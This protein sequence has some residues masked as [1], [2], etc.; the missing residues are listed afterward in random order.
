[1]SK[2]VSRRDFA[3]ASVAAGAAAVALPETLLGGATSREAPPGS[4]AVRGAEAARHRIAALPPSVAYGG[5]SSS[6]Q[7]PGAPAAVRG[8]RDGTTIPAEYY[9]DEKHYVNDERYIANNFWLL[10]DHT[11]RMPKPGDYFVFEFGRGDSVILLRN[12]A[13]AVKGYH[14][15]CRHR[16]SRLCRHDDDPTPKDARLSVKQL[17]PSGNSPV[18]RC[19]YHAS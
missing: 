15:V 19:P 6:Q 16:G 2:K 17:G 9:L 4:A 10:V 11:S 7:R 14:N 1:M 18:F 8:W 12:N 13:G 3:R 5:D